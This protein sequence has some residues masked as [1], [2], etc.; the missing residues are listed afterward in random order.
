MSTSVLVGLIGLGVFLL[1]LVM[2][3]SI[4]GSM[5]IVG[6]LGYAY[7]K[8]F[9]AAA[10]LL[11]MDFFS[12]FNSY[13]MSVV[14]MFTWMGYIA[15]HSGIGEK[16]FDF[17]YKLV[18]HWRGGLA[19]ASQVACACFGAVCGSNT[20]TA[21]TIGAIALPQMKKYNYNDS[22]A[23]A[24]VASGGALG[25][26][27][28]PSMI[29]I[30]YGTAT[31]QSIGK[32]FIAGITAGILLMLLFMLAI[33]IQLR[34]KPE[35]APRGE[36]AT[37]KE[38]LHAMGGGLMETVIVFAVSIGGLS[39]GFFTPTEAGAFGAFA[40]L[41]IVLVRK[42][43]TFKAF[44]LSLYDTAKT[45][46]MVLFLVAAATM[47]GRFIA[48]SRIPASLAGWAAALPWPSWAVLA[49]ILGIYIIGGCFIDA[50]PLVLLTVPIFQ[51]VVCTTLGYDPIWFGVIIVLVVSM[52]IITPPVGINVYVIKGIA[53]D[54]P[55]E[56][57][58]NGI[59]PFLFAIILCCVILMVFPQIVLF[60][61]N[62][63]A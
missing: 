7:L 1:L 51:P 54:V 32:L 41:L 50:L 30:V 48:L 12:S 26:L 44:M 24:S 29:A 25:I 23:T 31:Q 52:G 37:W 22:L 60:L 57:I 16:L 20:A 28:P 5:T 4:A 2:G 27:I 14:A 9:G 21:A 63:L 35:L 11:T 10:S 59:W 58:F 18:G 61:P 34:L 36:K 40:M 38:R 55:L 33:N 19:M 49:L 45:S 6:F 47:F 53:K 62:L 17:A 56:T 3:M 43:L 42:K 46:A 13:N 39:A 8:S 15:Y